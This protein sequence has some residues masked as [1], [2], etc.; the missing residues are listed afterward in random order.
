MLSLDFITLAPAFPLQH[1]IRLILGPGISAPFYVIGMNPIQKIDQ[2]HQMLLLTPHQQLQQE[3]LTS[4]SSTNALALSEAFHRV[5]SSGLYRGW[6]KF[7]P[8]LA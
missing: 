6:E 1:Y 8:A 5:E 2:N 4:R 3:F 7:V